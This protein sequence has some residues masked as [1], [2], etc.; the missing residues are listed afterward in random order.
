MIDQDPVGAFEDIRDSLIL[1]TKTAFGTRFGGIERDRETLL[2]A[3][4][5]MHREPW[6]ELRP[7]F[8]T[9]KA[10]RELTIKDLPTLSEE[11]LNDFISLSRCGLVGDFPLYSHQLEMLQLAISG[12]NAVIT[13]GTG[14]GKTEA[15]LL[16]LF[17]YLARESRKW[18][19]PG[20]APRRDWWNSP[21][22]KK[23]ASPRLPQRRH[24]T[25]R[26]AVRAL[27]LYPMNALV[28]DQMTRLRRALDSDEARKWYR[29]QR[30]GNRIYLGRYNGRTPVPGREFDKDGEPES[31][32]ID[33]LRDAMRDAE[34]SYKA[35]SKYSKEH[36]RPEVRDF[37]PAHDGSEMISRWDMQDAPP[38][39]LITNF[40][41]LSIMLMREGDGAIFEET[42]RWLQ[43]DDS[44]F[45]LI[46]DEL[47]LYRGTAGTEVAYLLKLLLY[48][49]GLT[50]DSPKLRILASS[51]S[52]T[53]DSEESFDFL[54][55]FFSVGFEKDQI[56]DGKPL[57]IAAKDG[58]Y[59]PS[60]A[61]AQ[62]G[63]KLHE[64]SPIRDADLTNAARELGY[65]GTRVGLEAIAEELNAR[66][67]EIAGIAQRAAMVNELQRAVAFRRLAAGMFGSGHVD[68][69]L[70]LRGFLH[71]RG[72]VANKTLPSFRFHWFFR[73]IEGLWACASPACAGDMDPSRPVGKLFNDTRIQCESHHRVYDL[74][75]CEQCGTVFLAG[76]R[77]PKQSGSSFELLAVDPALEGVPDRQTERFIEKRHHA[78]YAVFWPVGKSTWDEDA[79]TWKQHP[80]R[81]PSNGKAVKIKA[82]WS[83]AVLDAKTGM[84]SMEV[85]KAQCDKDLNRY[86]VGRVY[87][88]GA[89]PEHRHYSAL[90]HVCI[91]CGSDYERRKTRKSPLRGF[92]TGF[93]KVSQVLARTLFRNLKDN[94]DTR[95]IVVFSDSR[96]DAAGISAG[97]ERAHYD[98]LLRDAIY[99]ELLS[100]PVGELKLLEDI[101]SSGEPVSQEALVAA[102]RKPH[103]VKLLQ[104]GSKAKRLWEKA[105]DEYK[106]LLKEEVDSFARLADEIRT[107][108]RSKEVPLNILYRG[109]E[110]DH[111]AT[112]SLVQRLKGLGVNPSGPGLSPANYDYDGSRKP[113][114]NFFNFESA[115]PTYRAGLSQQAAGKLNDFKRNV[116]GQI[117]G[118]LFSRNYYSFEAS[119]LGFPRVEASTDQIKRYAAAAGLEMK[120]FTQVC[121]A[122]LRVLGDQFRF[123]QTE[124]GWEPVDWLQWNARARNFLKECAERNSAEPT[125]VAEAV[126]E[127]LTVLCGHVNLVIN[128]DRLNIRLTGENDP[129]WECDNCKRIHLHPSAGVC[130]LCL[131]E[132]S[133]APT[134]VCKEVYKRNYLGASASKQLK[135]FRLHSEELSA[136]TDDQ[137]RRQRH[138]RN[139]VLNSA[140]EIFVPTVEEIDVLSVTTTMEVGVDIGSLQA[141]FLANM[142][143]MRFNYQQRVGR[144]GRGGQPFACVL[145]LCRGRSH[146]DHYFRNPESITGDKPPVPFLS[147]NRREIVRRLAS[148]ECLRRAFLAVGVTWA[149]NNKDTHGEFGTVPAFFGH[150]GALRAWLETSPVVK[151]VC[152]ALLHNLKAS[153]GVHD[154]IKFIR[155]ELM[156]L[157]ES[158][159]QS[160]EYATPNVA[161]RLA[162]AA[163]L[164][165]FG[166]P[167]RSRSMYHGAR[168]TN[169]EARLLSIERDLDLAISEFAPGSERT[170]DKAIHTSIGFT[171]S[172]YSSGSRILAFDGPALGNHRFMARC[173]QCQF[174]ATGSEQ[175]QFVSC[176]KCRAPITSTHDGEGLRI[177][178]TAVP[179]AFRTTLREGRD[180]KDM[181]EAMPGRS[182]PCAEQDPAQLP[183]L[184]GLNTAASLSTGAAVYQV[185]D[186]S[187]NLFNVCCGTTTSKFL[188]LNQQLTLRKQ[189]IDARFALPGTFQGDDEGTMNLAI[190]SPKKTDVLRIH[191]ASVPDGLIVDPLENDVAVRAAYYSFAFLFRSVLAERLDIDS[192]E[193]DISSIRRAEVN[194]MPVGEIVLN[195][196]LANGAGFV[197]EAKK[198]MS[199]LLMASSGERPSKVLKPYLT[200][201]HQTCTTSCYQCLRQFRNMRFHGLL[202]WRLAILLAR[203]LLDAG[204]LVGLDG[205]FS[206]PGLKG[207]VTY[208]TALRDRFCDQYPNYKRVLLG[209]LPGAIRNENCI[210]VTHPLWNTQQPNRILA[211]A[212][213]ESRG[214]TFFVN[215]FN[216][217]R[218]LTWTYQRLNMLSASAQQ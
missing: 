145:T 98:D 6:I 20:T 200:P 176:P 68:A 137:P 105:D 18:P 22:T 121:D 24:E 62:L 29:E 8:A 139:I 96:E 12:R 14:S 177:F 91:S 57:N 50:P 73:N 184:Q 144:A 181:F 154:L 122:M 59:L 167:S 178:R 204:E 76:S 33:D 209:G 211:D 143:P 58:E 40:S 77:M 159:M 205:D 74:L 112:G 32:K 158:V 35:A 131:S 174:T 34:Q 102:A 196:R 25:R 203:V 151:D 75:Y 123:P 81:E 72:M 163:L 149:D 217:D 65:K 60:D 147:M 69:E 83:P 4:G 186:N 161:E 26:A 185:N 125:C 190:V 214:N 37:F 172:L 88:L 9:A 115:A 104:K 165:M 61:L 52:L 173:T 210:I 150:V 103:L 109:A 140:D 93:T 107:Q 67:P 116:Q 216:L 215:T 45:H 129:V 126:K 16:P 71:L 80:L 106:S 182:I 198:M 49:L 54:Q 124:D 92:R 48:R 42:R 15:F 90:P 64:S 55:Q 41:M 46:V 101:C 130:T 99:D 166:M 19:K 2:R 188:N 193:I 156:D 180:N 1:Y 44:I 148:K 119:G 168:I 82:N 169:G 218:R 138:F 28:E 97:V 164:P 171:P 108:A 95:K 120:I 118:A 113:W 155:E 141:V 31:R 179:S 7:T 197:A 11:E 78:E 43:Q 89:G 51:A 195:D 66:A 192:E 128:P 3:D 13:A 94:S 189:W 187:G 191:P 17:A 135:P 175:M 38:D 201:E 146:D 208:A 70:A 170:K 162:E 21:A 23:G 160:D 183:K 87:R 207:W 79:V 5:V 53:S 202:D 84:I 30:N 117:C 110:G 194:G 56:I 132:L 152:E 134:K 142:P 114:T 39:V 63:K 212:V 10:I 136:Q 47:H 36:S 133:A 85:N 213:A 157:V 100:A 199:D 86:I 206:K 111:L 127:C 153:F 27:I